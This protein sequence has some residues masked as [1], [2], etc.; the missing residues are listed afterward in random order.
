MIVLGLQTRKQTSKRFAALRTQLRQSTDSAERRRRE[1]EKQAE[2]VRQSRQ[3]EAIA[4]QRKQ[5]ACQTRKENG[6]LKGPVGKK[7]Q[8]EWENGSYSNT[9]E[10]SNSNEDAGDE[11]QVKE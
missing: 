6:Q 8:G 4:K 2:A 1:Q 5:K 3:S 9:E 7:K 11:N 10:S